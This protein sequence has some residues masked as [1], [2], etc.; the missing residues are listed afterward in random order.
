MFLHFNNNFMLLCFCLQGFTEKLL[1]LHITI[2][3][4]YGRWFRQLLCTVL[5]VVLTQHNGSWVAK[6]CFKTLEPKITENALYSAAWCLSVGL[7][8]VVLW[9][10]VTERNWIIW[11]YF[12]NADIKVEMYFSFW[13]SIISKCVS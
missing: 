5:D 11:N 10:E 6:F 9:N 4:Q 8:F 3:S 7:Q 1:T 13:H 2:K 12:P